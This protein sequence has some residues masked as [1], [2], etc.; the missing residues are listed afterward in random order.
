MPPFRKGNI[1]CWGSLGSYG[2]PVVAEADSETMSA[3]ALLDRDTFDSESLGLQWNFLRNPDTERIS[4][5]KNPGNLS[6]LGS[7]VSLDDEDALV[8]ILRRQQHIVCTVKTAIDFIPASENEEAGLVVRMNERHHYEIA[9]ILRNGKRQC[10]VRARIGFLNKELACVPIDE[11]DVELA[12]TADHT[13]YHFSCANTHNGDMPIAH[14]ETRY[15][16]TE[17]AGGFTGI[18]FGV[19]ATGNGKESTSWA[20]CDWFEY[21]K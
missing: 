5:T 4:L 21:K 17:V 2:W 11:G 18:F 9:I 6:L 8:G 15:L 3:L 14:A 12:I 16:S 10:C 7:A 19:Y 13:Y 20:V 1:P